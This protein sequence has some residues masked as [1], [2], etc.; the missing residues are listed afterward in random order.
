MRFIVLLTILSTCVSSIYAHQVDFLFSVDTIELAPSEIKAKIEIE[1]ILSQEST[2]AMLKKPQFQKLKAVILT[3][4]L[5]HFGVHRIYLGTN[6]A[7]PVVYSL[8]LGG[9]LGFLPIIDLIAIIT[10]KDLSQY[11][12]NDKVIMWV[13]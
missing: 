1:N 9:G 10:S 3:I 2:G 11:M 8:T 12:N 4:F 7:V 6:T 5:G 13:K